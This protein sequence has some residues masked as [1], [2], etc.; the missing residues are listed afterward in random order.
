MIKNIQNV[1][2]KVVPYFSPEPTRGRRHFA[3]YV[4]ECDVPLIAMDW[5][6]YVNL[7]EEGKSYNFLIDKDERDFSQKLLGFCPA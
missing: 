5:D 2:T 4:R 3:V 1:V 6:S 7:P